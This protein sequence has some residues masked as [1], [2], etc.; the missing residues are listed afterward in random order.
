MRMAHR[1]TTESLRTAAER[2]DMRRVAV[3]D[4]RYRGRLWEYGADMLAARESLIQVRDDGDSRG[5]DLGTLAEGIYRT[6]YK[7]FKNEYL[8]K[9]PATWLVQGLWWALHPDLDEAWL[10]L[11][12]QMDQWRRP[13]PRD[14]LYPGQLLDMV[15]E[16]FHERSVSAQVLVSHLSATY[17]SEDRIALLAGTPWSLGHLYWPAMVLFYA[18]HPEQA[19]QGYVSMP[20]GTVAL[21]LAELREA[22]LPG[23]WQE[24]RRYFE[25]IEE[26]ARQAEQ[27]RQ[28]KQGQQQPSPES[29]PGLAQSGQVITLDPRAVA[30]AFSGDGRMEIMLADG[31]VLVVPLSWSHRLASA[32][33]E[34]RE[35][36][37]ITA[38]GA[39]LS[40]PDL[41]EDIEVAALL[42][43]TG[44]LFDW[45]DDV[46]LD[47]RDDFD[48]PEDER[49]GGQSDP[50]DGE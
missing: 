39:V 28:T 48:A 15:K 18:E 1:Y 10:D 19:G 24:S 5:L 34:Q 7:S 6:D 42:S 50:E 37:R 8:L 23:P 26:R 31:R 49:V 13:D 33:P 43:A 21:M 16:L 46:A 27:A 40:W 4:Q 44:R 3:V 11:T 25:R 47:E 9:W 29:E 14:G 45:P 30:V 17:Q 38:D 35:Q 32:T 12:Y 20:E 2:W 41:D 22:W 36:V